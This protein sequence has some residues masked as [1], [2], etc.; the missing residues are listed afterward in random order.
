MAE[1]HRHTAAEGKQWHAAA[2][3]AALTACA[4]VLRYYHIGVQSFWTDEVLTL[5]AAKSEGWELLRYLLYDSS[6][7]LYYLLLRAWL[8]LGESEGAVRALSMVMGVAAVPVCYLLGRELFDRRVGIAASFFLAINPFHIYYSQETRY[9]ALLVFLVLCSTLFLARAYRTKRFADYAGYVLFSAA[10][11]LTHYYAGFVIF[12]QAAYFAVKRFREPDQMIRYVFCLVCVGLIFLAWT[13]MLGLQLDR[14]Q[15]ARE[16][17]PVRAELFITAVFFLIGG[18]EWGL[19]QLPLTFIGP[20]S[21]HYIPIALLML[22]PPLILF[23]FGLFAKQPEDRP[24][25]LARVLLILPLLAVVLLALKMPLFRPKYLL[26]LLPF[27]LVVLSAGLFRLASRNRAAAILL[28]VYTCMLA[29][30]SVVRVYSNDRFFREDWRS[31]AQWV[32]SRERP[33]DAV[34]VYN[35]YSVSAWTHYYRGALETVTVVSATEHPLHPPRSTVWRNL[36]RAAQKSR[37]LWIVDYQ[38]K[39]YDPDRSVLEL[40]DRDFFAVP[41]L[42]FSRDP[43]FAVRA[44]VRDRD[45]LERHFT[46]RVD[47]REGI[48]LEE[49]LLSG[50]LRKGPDYYWIAERAEVALRRRPGQG[51][52]QVV[53]YAY[54]PYFMDRVPEATVTVCGEEVAT[55]RIEKSELQV[56]T[57][58]IPGPFLD[59]D[60]LQVGLEVTP[61]FIPDEVLHDGDREPKSVIVTAISL[62][63]MGYQI[64]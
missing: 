57:A 54:L 38:A 20:E 62:L 7:P 19:P 14:G 17:L 16:F 44:Y 1:Q 10:A 46:D 15:P 53:F 43:R 64:R 25:G 59:R 48:Y 50:W 60:I 37:R 42:D 12:G 36:A 49:Q 4:F 6:P 8:H 22:A 47:F 58:V 3:V 45:E 33:G 13:P 5:Q 30:G 29:L 61:T 2:S 9:P 18:S 63:Y 41:Y 28:A 24:F 21:P 26:P 35:P 39:V 34:L 40:C 23:A 32:Q 52:V 55:Q 31:A 27:F 56:M 11:L 51:L